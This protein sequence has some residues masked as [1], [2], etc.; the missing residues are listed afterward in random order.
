MWFRKRRDDW[1]VIDTS[2][3]TRARE[4]EAVRA[5]LRAV[6]SCVYRFQCDVPWDNR[7][8]WPPEVVEA[9]SVLAPLPQDAAPNETYRMTGWVTDF[10]HETWEAFTL[11]APY[12]FGA[13]AWTLEMECVFDVSDEG[14]RLAVRLEPDHLDDFKRSIEGV[15]V[16]PAADWDRRRSEE[17]RLR[18]NQKLR[19]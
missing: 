7:P 6:L 5:A 15:E 10:D 1:H 14:S 13:D 11:I 18:Y 2:T 8:S 4:V 12:A 17:W 19:G 9:A 3:L 16:V